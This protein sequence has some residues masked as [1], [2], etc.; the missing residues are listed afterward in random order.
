MSEEIILQT[1]IYTVWFFIDLLF[2]T[3]ETFMGKRTS[4]GMQ[5][6]DIETAL[7]YFTSPVHSILTLTLLSSSL[8][9]THKVPFKVKSAVA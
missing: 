6:F 8:T 3:R 4:S 5:G 9:I 7:S 1:D 2:M